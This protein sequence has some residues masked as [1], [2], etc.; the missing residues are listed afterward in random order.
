MIRRI[1]PVARAAFGLLCVAAMLLEAIPVLTVVGVL[2]GLGILIIGNT[3]RALWVWLGS[4]LAAG[5]SGFAFLALAYLFWPL[6]SDWITEWQG[7]VM[8]LVIGAAGLLLMAVVVKI[9]HWP[10]AIE[11]AVPFALTFLVG[12]CIPG[13]FLGLAHSEL[14]TLEHRRERSARRPQ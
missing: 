8:G 12:F 13:W 3:D 10:L 1:D 6:A 5:L 11:L 4:W 2:G 7:Y 9:S 14:R